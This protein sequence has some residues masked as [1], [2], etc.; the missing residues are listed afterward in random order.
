MMFALALPYLSKAS[1][2]SHKLFFENRNWKVVSDF[3]LEM[4]RSEKLADFIIGDTSKGGYGITALKPVYDVG[5]DGEFIS[6]DMRYQKRMTYAMSIGYVGSFYRG[7]QKQKIKDAPPTV[8]NDLQTALS[9]AIVSAGRTDKNVSAVSQVI[10]FTCSGLET[11]QD[12]LNQVRE[13]ESCRSGH[14]AAY[15]CFRVPRKFNARCVSLYLY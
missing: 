15:E 4:V 14:L 3:W 1:K 6:K 5:C 13:H 12:F 7:F 2:V 8:E 9:R 10:S 11:P